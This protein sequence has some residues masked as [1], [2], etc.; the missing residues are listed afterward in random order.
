M[1]T[2]KR[3][4]RSRRKRRKNQEDWQQGVWRIPSNLFDAVPINDRRRVIL[5][6][7]RRNQPLVA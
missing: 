5:E 3:L 1:K 4:N 7:T 6:K 2:K